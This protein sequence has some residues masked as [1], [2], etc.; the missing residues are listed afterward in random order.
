VLL[1]GVFVLKRNGMRP[2]TPLDQVPAQLDK[3][4]WVFVHEESKPVKN[5]QII[6]YIKK[7]KNCKMSKKV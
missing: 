5:Q 1:I 2:P 6:G 3:F 4:C 7:A